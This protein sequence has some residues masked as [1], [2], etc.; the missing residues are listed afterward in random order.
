MKHH[1]IIQETRTT[2]SEWTVTWRNERIEECMERINNLLHREPSRAR[3]HPDVEDLT[4]A[5]KLAV[6]DAYLV[7]RG[8]RK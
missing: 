4:A 7:G 6:L 3:Y 1:H 2:E 5:I 8:E